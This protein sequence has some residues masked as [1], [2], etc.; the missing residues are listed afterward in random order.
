MARPAQGG[1]MGISSRLSGRW[2][3][4]AKVLLSTALLASAPSWATYQTRCASCH[5]PA[6]LQ[7]NEVNQLPNGTLFSGSIRSR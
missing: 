2:A 5:D 1:R 4:P 6:G 3:L 7:T